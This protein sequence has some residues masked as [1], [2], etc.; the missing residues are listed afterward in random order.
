MTELNAFIDGIEEIM[1]VPKKRSHHK[2]V[3]TIDDLE[4][5]DVL[6]TS[7]N[8]NNSTTVFGDIRTDYNTAR[9]HE[10]L[11]DLLG[12]FGHSNG[13]W[14]VKTNKNGQ[15]Y[16]DCLTD[17]QLNK[18]T[19]LVRPFLGNT[20]VN[21]YQ[22][23]MKFSNLFAYDSVELTKETQNKK[24]NLFTGFK[25][26][27]IETDDFTVLKP[28]LQHCKHIIC[29]DDERKYNYLMCWFASIFQNVTVKN[30]TMPI[31]I[32]AQGS[33]KSIVV[34]LF[35]ELLGHYA[36][37]N[38]DDLDKIFGKFNGLIAQ[39]LL[40]VIN[41]QP[42]ASEKF[43][44]SG[45]IKS[46]LTQ[47]KIIKETKGVDCV[48]VDSWTNYIMTTNSSQPV[49]EEKG[50]RRFIYYVTNNEKVGDLE[51]FKELHKDFQPVFQGEYNKTYMG[52]L[53]HYMRTQIDVTDF[54]P[55]RL[56]R[57]LSNE[58]QVGYNE[59]LER[60]YLDLNLIDKFVVDNAREFIKGV[61][62]SY[63]KNTM[64]G[65]VTGY[66]FTGICKCL[67]SICD[68]TRKQ[69]NKIQFRHYKLK[70]REQIPDL[71]LIIDYKM[72]N[73]EVKDEN[74]DRYEL[75]Y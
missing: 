51:Y 8:I 57:E 4:I 31:I 29:N 17:E 6:N 35:A 68:I 39:N 26:H 56:I 43:S 19:K 15:P 7:I 13:K 14:Y 24:I 49:R 2:Q 61:D 54:Q 28:F 52:I 3:P 60:Q 33:G 72:F 21:L 23:L 66:K 18:L 46:K 5:T 55:E 74:N 10:L 62:S 63:I 71:Y 48:E 45:K 58:T 11:N 37:A 36:N 40:I 70:P 75:T 20:K 69:V 73:G 32:G 12:V 22:I 25:Y 41:E 47:K 30:G 65:I 59:N 50:N 42:E 27:K 38:V 44:F 53:L 67:N 64:C 9:V 1:P 34:E 16:I